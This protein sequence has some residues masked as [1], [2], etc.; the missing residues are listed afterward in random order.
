MVKRNPKTT[1]NV[2]PTGDIDDTQMDAPPMKIKKSNDGIGV[3][4]SV[5]I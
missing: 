5:G 2:D 4:Q 1:I 3:Y